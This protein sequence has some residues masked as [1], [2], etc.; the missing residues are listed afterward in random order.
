MAIVQLRHGV[1]EADTSQIDVTIWLVPSAEAPF[2]LM[3]FQASPRPDGP[4]DGAFFCN[5]GSPPGIATSSSRGI[6]IPTSL[7]CMGL[8][9]QFCV[10]ALR[11]ALTCPSSLRLLRQIVRKLPE[12]GEQLFSVRSTRHGLGQFE[13]ERLVGQDGH[14]LGPE[15]HQG[16]I[17]IAR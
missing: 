2:G 12:C 4:P 9:S 7:R 13:V 16:G 1:A 17:D 3:N 14:A 10:R 11:A 15:P 8:F 6:F 5:Q